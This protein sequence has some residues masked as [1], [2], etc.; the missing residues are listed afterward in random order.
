MASFTQTR[1]DDLTVAV[2]AGVALAVFYSHGRIMWSDELF[3]WM[4]ATDPSSRH[5][6][7]AW[8]AGADGGGLCFYVLAR[9]WLKVF[10]QSVLAFR[11][12]SAA[13]VAAAAVFT[14]RA[15]RHYVSW[16]IAVSSVALLWFSSDIVLWQVMQA[17]FYGLLLAGVAGACYLAVL[18]AHR[19]T[20]RLLVLT[21]VCH[22]VLVGTHPFGAVYSGVVVLAMVVSDALVR[23]LRT[24]L[25]AAALG[26]WWVLLVSV[27]AMRSTAAV[28]RPHFWTTRPT[29]GDLE[30]AYACWSLA[31][32][33]VLGTAMAVWFVFLFARRNRLGC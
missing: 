9:C 12:F 2:L 4:L 26:G 31:V 32:A 13:G 10:G 23:R 15:A 24:Q 17:R 33:V 8:N 6:I 1:K 28:G 14:F 29:I 27:R 7:E 22:T 5:M 20:G 30:N 19:V 11:L 21:W 16:G 3:G 18:T 25:Y